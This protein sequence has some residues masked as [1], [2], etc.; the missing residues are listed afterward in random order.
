[1]TVVGWKWQY[2]SLNLLLESPFSM[3][4]N[5]RAPSSL[6]CIKTWSIRAVSGVKLVNLLVGGLEHL[7][8]RHSPILAIF[9]P[10]PAIRPLAFLSS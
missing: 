5:V 10:Y 4:G 9:F 3:S 7:S 8:S 2:L 1:M 6:I